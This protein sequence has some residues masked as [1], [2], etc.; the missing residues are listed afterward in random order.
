MNTAMEH[1]P[2]QNRKRLATVGIVSLLFIW[3]LTTA[4]TA[5]E[6][7]KQIGSDVSIWSPADIEKAIE[8]IDLKITRSKTLE[9]EDSL[10]QIGITLEEAKE[11]IDTYRTLKSAYAEL[12]TAFRKTA[13][14]QKNEPVLREK[15]AQQQQ[16]GMSQ[17][18]PYSLGFYDTLLNDLAGTDRLEETLKLE[19]QSA[20][21]TIDNIKESAKT[22]RRQLNELLDDNRQPAEGQ[23][24]IQKWKIETV[25][26]D[27][28]LYEIYENTERKTLENLALEE[29]QNGLEKELLSQ[30]ITWV[31]QHLQVDDSDLKKWVATIEKET[32]KIEQRIKQLSSSKKSADKAWLKAQENAQAAGNQQDVLLREI[33]LKSAESWK[34]TYQKMLEQSEDI[35]LLLDHQKQVLQLRNQLF[36]GDLSQIEVIKWKNDIEGKIKSSANRVALEQMYLNS[37]LKQIETI[38]EGITRENAAGPVLQKMKDMITALRKQSDF[39]MDFISALLSAQQQDQRFLNELK[40]KTTSTPLATRLAAFKNQLESIWN[41]EV[42][43]IDTNSVTVGKLFIALCI[44]IIGMIVSKV[45]LRFVAVRLHK[46][47]HIRETTA[48]TI[49]KLLLYFSYLMVLLLALKTVNIPLAAF[50]FVGGAV[51]IGIGFGAQNLISNFIS[52]FIIMAEQPISIGDLMEVDG[53]LGRVEEIGAR[54]TRIRTGA[55]IHILVPNSSFLEKNITNWTLSDN[56]IRTSVRVGVAYGSDVEKAEELLSK[57]AGDNPN[58]LTRPSPFVIFEDFGDNALIFDVYFWIH[59]QANMERRIIESKIRYRIN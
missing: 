38:E 21:S 5:Q 28:E 52:G 27:L 19:M 55:N 6:E 16:T 25:R 47:L 24:R 31:R 58:V 41:F 35:I 56:R 49:Q 4:A 39:G 13:D 12:L 29:K 10:E 43:V 15:L 3:V 51:V 54:S 32:E 18:P 2:M 8:D 36:K 17:K 57:A 40:L 37:L 30:Q 11:R 59:I 9:N 14:Y 26:L 46:N 7:N 22:S 42:W 48:S 53:V 44:L 50:A 20:K 33:N 1:R 45:I 34:K 23:S